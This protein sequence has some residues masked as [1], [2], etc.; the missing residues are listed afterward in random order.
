MMERKDKMI[1]I[2]D[3]ITIIKEMGI[4]WCICRTLYSIKLKILNKFPFF[5]GMF[6]KKH[7]KIERVDL[8]DANVEQLEKYF[9]NLPESKK[10]SILIKAD[11][12]VEGRIE[13][14][15]GTVLD[16]KN[17]IQWN[18]NPITKKKYK[19]KSKWY[20]IVDFDQ[21]LGDIKVIWELNRFSHCWYL[22]R[23]YVITHDIKYFKSFK[24]Q[25]VEWLNV[26]KYSYGPNY[27]CGQECSLRI[28]NVLAAVG[29]FNYYNLID[30]YFEKKVEEF[31]ERNYQK[32]RSNFFY[33]NHCVKIDHLISELC[34]QIVGAYCSN[35]MQIARKFI[36]KLDEQFSMQF[37]DIGLYKTYSLNYQR[38]VL[39]LFGYMLHIS[40][41]IGYDFSLKTK[42]KILKAAQVYKCVKAELGGIPNYGANDGT[43][44]F[45]FVE[46]D[47]YLSTANSLIS[48]L[49]GRKNVCIDEE[50]IW[51]DYHGKFFLHIEES[52]LKKHPFIIL[53]NGTESAMFLN[54]H[55][56]E[57]RPGH[58]DQLHVELWVEG[59]N[60][61]CDSGTYSYALPLGDDLRKTRGHNTIKISNKEQMGGIGRFL[62]YGKP[63][64]RKE[65][66]GKNSVEVEQEFYTGYLHNRKIVKKKCGYQIIDYVKDEN[67]ELKYSIFFHTPYKVQRK[68]E[69][70]CEIILDNRIVRISS[71]SAEMKSNISYA[72]KRYL[73][74]EEYTEIEFRC[75]NNQHI[76]KI[77]VI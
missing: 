33:A 31:V 23:A 68:T 39:Q 14:F 12:C 40:E 57:M 5:E 56:Y 34:G 16:Y 19:M 53:K 37:S 70:S 60:V 44:I 54:S 46:Y 25:I 61:F 77:E 59:K 66:V 28:M 62:I 9:K 36:K 74:K 48:A 29:V 18:Y 72:S 20:T 63:I 55:G 10:K 21:N 1:S 76:T 73:D 15:G 45:P 30:D 75:T 8:Y 4:E 38:F 49:C 13:A 11:N 7:R 42:E 67:D 47:D 69:K 58:M 50:S 65:V 32:I 43:L 71:D 6:E 35:N 41:K 26:N 51:I 3:I 27:K 22:S 24:S 64:I 2:R 17:P 52:G